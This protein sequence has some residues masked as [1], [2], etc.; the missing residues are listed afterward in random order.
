MGEETLTNFQR[1]IFQLAPHGRS[2]F[3]PQKIQIP[4]FSKDTAGEWWV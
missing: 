4:D 3:L 2:H 1:L